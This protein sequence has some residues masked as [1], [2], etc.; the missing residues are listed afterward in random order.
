MSYLGNTFEKGPV[1]IEKR[2]YP[3]SIGMGI[4]RPISV[5]DGLV[6]F[7][8]STWLIGQP[9]GQKLSD[10][11]AP[12]VSVENQTNRFYVSEVICNAALAKGGDEVI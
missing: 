9:F 1:D 11:L 5:A 6:N 2:K 8:N 12:T 7:T 3:S 10:N 4:L